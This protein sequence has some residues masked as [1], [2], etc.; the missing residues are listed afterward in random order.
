MAYHSDDFFGFSAFDPGRMMDG[1]R[2][3]AERAA[4]Q[5]RQ[6]GTRMREA[7]GDA[8]KTVED[9]FQSARAGS[10][11]IGMR[12]A[13]AMRSSADLSMAH[14]QALAGVRSL[15]DL[16]ELQSRFVRQHAE[17]VLEQTRGMHETIRTAAEQVAKPG[18]AAA[19]RAMSAFKAA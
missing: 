5:S 18:V 13:D 7:V 10:L 17:L 14:V 1:F 11:E 2:D 12:A 16:F 6:A 4:E 8:T 19:E 15:P 3:A 9:T